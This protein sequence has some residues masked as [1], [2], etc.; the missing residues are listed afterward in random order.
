MKVIE[1]KVI[2]FDYL[3]ITE[4]YCAV[5]GIKF[6]N[7]RCTV[8]TQKE[9]MLFFNSNQEFTEYYDTLTAIYEPHERPVC[10]FVQYINKNA[11]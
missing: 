5:L 9:K 3:Q 2:D 1:V 10:V 8:F 6:P 11:E 7:T 4:P